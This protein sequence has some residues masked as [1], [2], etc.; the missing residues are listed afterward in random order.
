M[1]VFLWILVA[2][3]VIYLGASLLIALKM[4]DIVMKAKRKTFERIQGQEPY[5]Q[6]GFEAYE[7]LWDRH[8]FVLPVE[9]AE[10]SGEYILNPDA[11]VGRKKVAIICHGHTVMRAS[12]LKY[13]WMF[14]R[15]GYQ[16]IIF[17]ERYFGKSTGK[18]CTLGMMESKDIGALERF[19]REVFGEDAFIAL[20]GESMGAASALLSLDYETPDLVI[21]DC[22]FRTT[23][24]Q[25][26]G[27][28][29]K[30]IGIFRIPALFFGRFIG[31][32]R[33]GYDYTKINPCEAVKKADVPICFIHGLADSYIP[34]EH[35][36]KMYADCKN[37]LSELHLV[38]EA[39]HALSVAVD[40]E[41]YVKRIE[42][43]V[44]KVESNNAEV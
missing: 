13:A 20:H 8:E 6:R 5:D 19:A 26:D 1:R 30:R 10:I 23:R 24:E 7:N 27:V 22:P 18:Y 16:I 41:G 39:E 42:N 44:R 38:P 31:L 21:A 40:F 12:D 37:P 43:F 25:L 33:A 32:A 17:D 2:V 4:I 3:I 36:Q 15:L 34:C 11:P 14:Y 9:G 29:R 28:A 35:S